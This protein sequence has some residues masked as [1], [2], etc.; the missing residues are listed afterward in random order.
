MRSRAPV[1]HA[2]LS[3]T[4]RQETRM[5]RAEQPTT[6]TPSSGATVAAV[7]ALLAMA[8][9]GFFYAVSGLVVPGPWLYLMWL[10]YLGLLATAG[11]LARR[12]SY[13]VLAVPVVGALAW[14]SLV[15]LGDAYWGWTG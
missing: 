6:R 1:D 12:R 11:W 5:T 3:T 14:W 10:L 8:P 7:L 2:V 13:L 15:S 9:V 4:S